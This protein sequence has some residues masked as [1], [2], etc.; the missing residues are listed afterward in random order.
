[1]NNERPTNFAPAPAAPDAPQRIGHKGQVRIYVGKCFRV[2]LHEK[3]WK[4]LVS[5]ALISLILCLVIGDTV[6]TNRDDTK[7]GAFALVCGCLWIGLFNSI[8]S[9]CRER[10]II[11]REHRTGLRISAYITAHMEFEF[12]QCLIES[13]IFTVIFDIFADFPGGAALLGYTGIEFFIGFLLLTFAA[14]ALG[15]MVSCIVKNENTAM[16]VMPFVL[17]I[18]LVLSGSI[19]HIESDAIKNLMISKWGQDAICCSANASAM[20]A[21]IPQIASFVNFPD[22]TNDPGKIFLSWIVLAAFAAGFAVIGAIFLS[23][24][25]HDKR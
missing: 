1:M 7:N 18:Q 12:V 4:S 19:F 9:I 8:Q 14:D 2:F 13:V 10:A 22:Y 23:F 6:F 3:G 15:I 16:T 21:K 11:K 25:D 17:I 20:Q 24:V 5:A